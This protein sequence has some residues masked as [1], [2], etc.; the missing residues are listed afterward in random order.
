MQNHTLRISTGGTGFSDTSVGKESTCNAGD[1]GPVPRLGRSAGEGIGYPFQF[2]WA[3][4]VAQLVKNPPAIRENWVW[5]LGWEDP[6]EKGMANHSSILAWR[7]PWTK[8]QTLLNDFHIT[9]SVYSK[10]Y[11]RASQVVLVVKN[12]PA[13]AGDLRGTGSIPGL[14]LS[15]RGEHGKPL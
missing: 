15:P 9:N 5:S 14:E 10:Y 6:L 2:S 3:S 8:R 7:V 12:P 1:P 13:N 11:F 4:L